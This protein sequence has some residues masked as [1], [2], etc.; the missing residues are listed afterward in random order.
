[1]YFAFKNRKNIK[2]KFFQIKKF[3][4]FLFEGSYGKIYISQP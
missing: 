1:M 3:L 4:E 2:Y